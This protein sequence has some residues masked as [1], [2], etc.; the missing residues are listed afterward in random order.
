MYQV[1]ARKYRPLTFDEVVGQRHIVQ[2]LKRAIQE[3]RIAHAYL[4]CGQR[5]V[6]KTSLARIFARAVNC[7]QGPTVQP[8]NKCSVCRE[9]VAGSCIDVLEIDAA[10]NRG[11]EE[12]RTIR[13]N[14]TLQP[15]RSR[16]KVYVIDEVHMLTTEAFNALLKTLEEPPEHIIFIL[17][18][19]APEKITLTI[20]SRCQRFD[21]RPLSDQ[22]IAQK[23]KEIAEQE[24]VEIEPSALQKI[25]GFASGS[26]RDSLSVLDQLIVFSPDNRITEEQVRT[27]LG[28]VEET[29]IEEIIRFCVQGKPA[30]AIQLLHE[31]LKEGKDGGVLLGELV[32]KLRNVG[33]ALLGESAAFPENEDFLAVFHG[34]T[35]E[36]ILEAISLVLEYREKMRRE[37]V[38]VVLLEILFLKLTAIL[39]AGE[40]HSVKGQPNQRQKQP[41]GATTDEIKSVGQ[42]LW[43]KPEQKKEI[44]T[45]PASQPD[46]VQTEEKTQKEVASGELPGRWTEVLSAVKKKNRTVEACLREGR[47]EKM[48]GKTI[49][50]AY[51]ARFS[52]H[53]GMVERTHNRKLVEEAIAKVFGPGYRLQISTIGSE[54]KPLLEQEEV[55]KVINFFQGEIVELEE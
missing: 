27:L 19:T 16:Y 29:A 41:D 49:Y 31:L 26:M 42:T 18:T 5:G 1:L 33:F 11:I 53:Q 39:T 46:T 15:S 45:A 3:G 43:E 37:S 35:T 4:F 36:N 24:K 25:V 48:E 20:L 32:K 55:R 14:V 21:F 9:I 51:P 13:E 28:L 50:L 44:I 38:P 12:I 22:E 6:G 7:E 52:F 30:K 47:L 2:S 40:S 54:E 8:C 23:V 10:S 34:L 17:A